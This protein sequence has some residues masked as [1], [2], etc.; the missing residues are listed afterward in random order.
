MVSASRIGDKL[1]DTPSQP[2]ST[3]WKK[4]NRSNI[5][6]QFID[7][8]KSFSVGQH[9]VDVLQDINLAIETGQFVSIIGESGCGKTTLLRI[10][11]GLIPPTKGDVL[12]DDTPVTRPRH[13]IGFVFQQS[14]LLEWRTV[15]ENILLPIEIFKLSLEEYHSKALQ[16]LEMMGLSEFENHYPIQLSG[17]MQQ[18]VAIARALI[19]SPSML[20]MDEPFGALDAITREQMNVELL[21]IWSLSRT[22]ALFVTHDIAE[23]VY[24]SDRVVV[25]S[26]R[27][28][29]IRSVFDIDLSR[30]RLPEQRFEDRFTKLCRDMKREMMN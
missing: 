6:L 24:L 14:V 21:R 4:E 25:L 9:R 13:D 28:G 29:R 10:A 23:A 16:L 19:F 3:H 18:R 1:L 22:T 12:I 26:S 17:G 15:I 8:M 30:P 5:K 11:G 20:L 27:P 2:E 7:L